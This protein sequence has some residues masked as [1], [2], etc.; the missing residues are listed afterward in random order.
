MHVQVGL[1]VGADP[2][3]CRWSLKGC[4]TNQGH[5]RWRSELSML[6]SSTVHHLITGTYL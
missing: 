1:G 3:L 4:L 6:S 2:C 5:I